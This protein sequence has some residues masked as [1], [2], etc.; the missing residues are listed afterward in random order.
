MSC[1]K[2]KNMILVFSA[3]LMV[4]NDPNGGKY[5]CENELLPS[6]EIFH[7]RLQLKADFHCFLL[8]RLVK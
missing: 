1:I 3:V 8:S 5:I 2:L 6:G 7:E 4:G